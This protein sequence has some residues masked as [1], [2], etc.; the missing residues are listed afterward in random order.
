MNT[1]ENKE[2][3]EKICRQWIK[4]EG[5]D[6]L[7]SWLETTDFYTTPA[8]TRFHLM[9]EGGLC[10]HS[11]NVFNRLCDECKQEGIFDYATTQETT[12]IMETLAVVGLFHD[13]CKV[14]FYTVSERNVKNEY[15]EWI[16]VPYYAI[17]NK[18]ILVGHGYKSARL[19]N[20]YINITDEEYMAIVHHMGYSSDDN[21]SNISEIFNKSE[22]S[23]LLH[24]ADTK[25][26]FID[27]NETLNRI[28]GD[29]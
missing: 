24:I 8:S 16:K 1:E 9:C 5:L 10:Q 23:L 13:L 14:N 17:D 18:G 27:E 2:K 4:R 11:I 7:L 26:T 6:N 21:I 22:L 25:A 3:F 28:K 20:K 29:N 19:V 12:K 15:G